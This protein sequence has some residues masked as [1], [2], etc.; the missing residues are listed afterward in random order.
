MSSGNGYDY[1]YGRSR[2]ESEWRGR[3]LGERQQ[4]AATPSA[5]TFREL[6]LDHWLRYN[7]GRPRSVRRFP[8]QP[9]RCSP[10]GAA[11]ESNCLIARIRLLNLSRS[12]QMSI[13]ATLSKRLQ[14][15]RE[16][17][18]PL[19]LALARLTKPN[20]DGHL[21]HRRYRPAEG[22][23]SA[24]LSQLRGSSDG[25]LSNCRQERERSRVEIKSRRRR[26]F[27]RD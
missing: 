12:S 17:P 13:N 20:P 5:G 22:P 21:L 19:G 3:E 1:G 11:W 15:E 27:R 26:R 6:N 16:P 25:T 10:A 2:P 9:V 4:V 8:P 18:P 7:L 23:S 14:L 24:G